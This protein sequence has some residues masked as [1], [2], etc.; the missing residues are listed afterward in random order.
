[1]TAVL[2]EYD[3]VEPEYVGSRTTPRGSAMGTGLGTEGRCV[4]GFAFTF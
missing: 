3:K 2:D 4:S 1:M